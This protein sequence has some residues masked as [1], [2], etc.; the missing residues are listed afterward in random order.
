MQLVNAKTK[1][2][3]NPGDEVKTFRGEIGILESYQIPHHSGSTSITTDRTSA[4]PG[5]QLW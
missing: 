4:I 3:A 2:P 1:Q 5:S